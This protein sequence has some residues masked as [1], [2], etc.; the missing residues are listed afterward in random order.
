VTP[1]TP[2]LTRTKSGVLRNAVMISLGGLAFGLIAAVLA[3]KLDPH[4]YIAEDVERTLGFAPMAQLPDFNE[5]SEGVA[6]EYVLRLAS[7]VEHG[8]SRAI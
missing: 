8:A 3:Q 6:E 7:A 1:A 4:V 2:P 5:V